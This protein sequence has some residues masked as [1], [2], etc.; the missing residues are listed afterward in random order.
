[1]AG[2]LD[3]GEISTCGPVA[4]EVLAGLDAAT[5]ERMWATLHSLPWIATPPEL[6]REVGAAAYRLRRAG[7]TLPLTDLAIAVAAARAEHALWSFD[8]DFER[9]HAVL[10]ELDLYDAS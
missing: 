4:A 5:A 3:A 8:S 6:W 1:M 10:P 7:K 9:I 2:L